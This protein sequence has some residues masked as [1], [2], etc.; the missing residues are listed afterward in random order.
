ME[1]QYLFDNEWSE[2]ERAE[3][4]EDEKALA[5]RDTWFGIANSTGKQ[6]SLQ[7]VSIHKLHSKHI[8]KQ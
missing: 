2:D 5:A 7:A 8:R 6:I 1:D 3:D 4:E